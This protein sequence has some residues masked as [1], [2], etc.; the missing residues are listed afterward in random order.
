MVGAIK[1]RRALDAIR[2]ALSQPSRTGARYARW[3]FDALARLLDVSRLGGEGAKFSRELIGEES[4]RRLIVEARKCV[5]DESVPNPERVAAVSLVGALALN[6]DADRERLLRLLKPQVDGSIQIAAV[7][8]LGRSSHRSIPQ[9]LIGDWKTYSPGVRSAVLDVLLSRPEWTRTLLSSLED[10]CTD[11]AEIDSTN[12][13]RLL[14][15]PDPEI[16][17]RAEAIFSQRAGRRDE[18]LKAY[19]KSLAIKG[20]ASTGAIIF[21]KNCASCHRI[22]KVGIEVGPDLSALKDRSPEALLIAILDPNRAFE[23]KYTSYTVATTDGRVLTGLVENES[24]NS[25]LLKRQEGKRESLLRSEIERMIAS[26]QSLMPE[27]IE[28]DLPPQALAD[29]IAFLTE[30]FAPTPS[31]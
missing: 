30:T 11:S 23:A 31:R 15:N 24:G 12:R 16:K 13:S 5:A 10:M 21:Q 20:N 8:A 14:S 6:D 1:D 3:Q 25:V 7:E 28:K 9:Q 4:V 26:G 2:T 18:V 29:L 19:Q 22:G 27:G 17:A